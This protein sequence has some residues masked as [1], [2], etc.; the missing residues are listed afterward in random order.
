MSFYGNVARSLL[1]PYDDSPRYRFVKSPFRF[2]AAYIACASVILS[3]LFGSVSTKGDSATRLLYFVLTAACFLA[4]A[5][6]LLGRERETEMLAEYNLERLEK[7]RDDMASGSGS[8]ATSNVKVGFDLHS[9]TGLAISLTIGATYLLLAPFPWQLLGGSLRMLLVAP[10]VMLWW[11]LLFAGVFPGLIRHDPNEISGCSAS[12]SHTTWIGPAIQSY[13]CKYRFDLSATR[14]A[15]AVV[16][17][18]C[19]S[20]KSSSE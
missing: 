10:E 18:F 8:D 20:W 9:P 6:F 15:F 3:F 16:D 17:H 4:V 5:F 12:I 19:C 2:Y 1:E 14:S 13:V 7:Y 11:W